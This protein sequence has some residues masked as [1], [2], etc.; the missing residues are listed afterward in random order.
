[1]VN[2]VFDIETDAIDATKIWCIVAYD[3][4]KHEIYSFVGPDE[5][6]KKGLNLLSKADKLIGHNIIGFDIPVIK[7]LYGI[8]LAGKKL[9]DTLVLSRLFNPVREGNHS[10]ESWGYRL[11]MHKGG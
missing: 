1:M 8:N 9:V 2:L 4:D 11:G 6:E 3:I 7:K 10:L 5:I